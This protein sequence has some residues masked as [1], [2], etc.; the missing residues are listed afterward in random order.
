MS[1][2]SKV[3]K[4]YVL[5]KPRESWQTDEHERFVKAVQEHGRNW[6]KIEGESEGVASSEESDSV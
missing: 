2:S 3:R 5:T 4:A 6:K 1:S